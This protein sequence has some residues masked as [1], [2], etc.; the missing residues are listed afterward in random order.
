[1]TNPILLTARE[2]AELRGTTQRQVQRVAK[3]GLLPVYATGPR[4][5]M[6]FRKSD[7]LKAPTTLK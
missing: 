2:V 7:A 6:L 4:N 3:A 1:M 5:T